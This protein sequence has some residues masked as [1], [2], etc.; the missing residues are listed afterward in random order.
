MAKTEITRDD[1]MN[2]DTYG[3]ERKERRAAVRAMKQNRRIHCGPHATFY[4]ESHATMFHQI[5]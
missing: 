1:I 3:A 5:H 2:M 4:F